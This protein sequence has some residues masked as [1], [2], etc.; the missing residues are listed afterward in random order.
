MKLF[1]WINPLWIIDTFFTM[2]LEPITATS[3]LGA[4]LGAGGT[5]AANAAITG[6]GIGALGSAATG[7]D[8]LKGA[9]IG[10]A[11]GGGGSL[12]GVGGGAAGAV[13]DVATNSA[14]V[15]SNVTPEVATT[16]M[17]ENIPT[18]LTNEATRNAAAFNPSQFATQG[19]TDGVMNQYAP[20]FADIAMGKS[21]DFTGGGYGGSFLN[22]IGSSALDALKQNPVQTASLGLN[23]YDRMNQQPQIQASQLG[24][25]RP[26]QPGQYNPVLNAM[27]Q[28]RNPYSL[29]G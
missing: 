25:I 5:A 23:V 29:L 26:Q 24:I 17:N 4:M 28:K 16:F 22:N 13:D 21:A 14:N 11:L 8:P 6:A 15:A 27:L 19:F 20:N 7:S 3:A 9:L 1:N 2:R 18:L 12:L 10:G